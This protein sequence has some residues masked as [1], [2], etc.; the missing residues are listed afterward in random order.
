[1]PD[2]MIIIRDDGNTLLEPFYSS[3]IH[4]QNRKTFAKLV[5]LNANFNG[6]L[7]NGTLLL[8]GEHLLML[9]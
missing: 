1:M 5:F 9:A 4:P 3:E 7:N 2:I 8:L 6:T